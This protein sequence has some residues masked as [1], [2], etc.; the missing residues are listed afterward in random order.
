[1]S[2]SKISVAAIIG[3]ASMAGMAAAQTAPTPEQRV[4]AIKQSLQTSQ[5]QLRKLEWV[6]TTIVSLKGEEKARSRKRV[7]YG[8]DGKLQKIA[9]GEAPAPAPADGGG[10][11][12]GRLK[13]KVVENKKSD[14]QEYMERAA[15]LIHR[16][17][18]PAPE[19]IQKAK[20]AGK[21][22]IA[23]GEAKRIRVTMKDYLQPGDTMAVDVDAAANTLAALSVATWLDKAEDT[24][25]L[26]V[27]WGS[28]Q[29]G[30]SYVAQTTLGAAAK[31]I[32]VVIQNAGHRPLTQ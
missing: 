1:M 9:I 20:D 29:D 22:A 15:A 7:Y 6:E 11:R 23:P 26:A 18:P 8:A 31:H 4:A 19:Q 5:A 28:L 13:A 12:S 2:L 24:V 25:A 17:V 27:R 3:L 14:I 21:L 32:Q 30:T 10:R 16:Y